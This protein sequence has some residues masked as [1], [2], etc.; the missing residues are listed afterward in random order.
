MAPNVGLEGAHRA[1]PSR[2][3]DF[4]LGFGKGTR[5]AARA[6]APG[7]LLEGTRIMCR[8]MLG[9]VLHE[10]LQAIASL[11]LGEERHAATFLRVSAAVRRR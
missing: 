4:C 8:E 3:C 7:V 1:L 5:S 9:D 6:R 10:D 11:P 2:A